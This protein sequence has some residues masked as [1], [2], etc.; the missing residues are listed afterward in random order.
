MQRRAGKGVNALQDMRQ[1]GG[2]VEGRSRGKG[3]KEGRGLSLFR[4]S[5]DAV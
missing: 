1:A 4:V 2:R 3:V 5:W